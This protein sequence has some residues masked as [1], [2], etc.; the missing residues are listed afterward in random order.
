[1]KAGPRV[2]TL[3]ELVW[4]LAEGTRFPHFWVRDNTHEH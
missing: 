4:G 1:M 3:R 2:R